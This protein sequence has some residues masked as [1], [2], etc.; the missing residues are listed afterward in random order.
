MLI[1][2][3]RFVFGFA[4]AA[5]ACCVLIWQIPLTTL[6]SI[7]FTPALLAFG[8]A[9]VCF[10][11]AVIS[12]FIRLSD[13]LAA[14]RPIIV[15]LFGALNKTGSVQKA[16]KEGRAQLDHTGTAVLRRESAGSQRRLLWLCYLLLASLAHSFLVVGFGD[17]VRL[18]VPLTANPTQST[19]SAE[20]FVSESKS[21]FPLPVKISGLSAGPGFAYHLTL[22]VSWFLSLGQDSQF[23]PSGSQT[24][25]YED[26]LPL[27]TGH[28]FYARIVESGQG[29]YLHWG[30][31]GFPQSVLY[32][33]SPDNTDPIEN[34]RSYRA[35]FTVLPSMIAVLVIVGFSIPLYARVYRGLNRIA[36][37]PTRTTIP[38]PA[39]AG[40]LLAIAIVIVVLPLVTHW[41]TGRSIYLAL[42]GLLPW[43]DASG[44]FSRSIQFLHT[45]AIPPW[46]LRRPL[47]TVFSG[48]LLFLTGER[49]QLVLIIRALLAA[50]AI[51]FLAREALRAY[52][53]VAGV[54]AFAMLASFAQLFGPML[55]SEIPGLALGAAGFTL[56]WQSAESKSLKC[57]ATGLLLLVLAMSVRPGALL[58]I[59]LL[60][61]WAPF[62]LAKNRTFE[63][64]PLLV[65]M[66]VV[67]LGFG[68]S[69]AFAML[70]GAQGGTPGANYGYVLYGLAHGGASWHLFFS[71]HPE[72]AAMAEAD[73]SAIAV[74]L[75]LLEIRENPGMFLHGLTKFFGLYTQ[76][77]FMYVPGGSI[78]S[79]TKIFALI[80]IVLALLA[81]KNRQNSL[82]V[83]GGLGVAASAPLVFWGYDAYRAFIA[84]SPIEVMLCAKGLGRLFE[85]VRGDWRPIFAPRQLPESKSD[86]G[87]WVLAITL[88]LSLTLLP[89][90]AV[91]RH[92]I[93]RFDEADC[94]PELIPMT[95]QLG[96]SSPAIEIVVGRGSRSL[97]VRPNVS[98]ADFR[99]NPNFA[100]N[101]RASDW[102]QVEA[103]TLLVHGINLQPKIEDKSEPPVRM[104]LIDSN[105]GLMDGRYYHICST[106]KADSRDGLKPLML[107]KK[108]RE[109]TVM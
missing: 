21:R 83:A 74:K 101:E 94:P 51:F 106:P 64:T 98:L 86:T 93:P 40:A 29:T 48:G 3:A 8:A 97:L 102:L 87:P 18:E 59:P 55:M 1:F 73:N 75:A 32:F 2:A 15:R 16:S 44:W 105:F 78:R 84:T 31:S 9:L 30:N 71:E 65:A 33:S 109:A 28:A 81:I 62:A 26:G 7:G 50:L 36:A 104:V 19:G 77:L 67:V 100:N 41:W 12:G 6:T 107:A 47:H 63:W 69:R 11:L 66:G 68:V 88:I 20:L 57:Y 17:S 92:A 35:V 53:L 80:G 72:L 61:L 79:C 10:G 54:F 49:L 23:S 99:Q 90:V 13:L 25:V 89:L 82:L 103:G 76:Y 96:R 22:Q 85:V 5:T 38:G 27:P 34:G 39:L 42:G 58:V 60:C 70:F 37:F 24:V 95:I 108:I 4:L 14:Q 52:G 43:S 46:G 91:Y 56:L 45:E